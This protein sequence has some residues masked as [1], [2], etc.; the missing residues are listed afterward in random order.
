MRELRFCVRILAPDNPNNS[1]GTCPG[2]CQF[3]PTFGSLILPRFAEMFGAIDK[4]DS[5]C[6]LTLFRDSRTNE[7]DCDQ[8]LSGFIDPD[9]CGRDR[10]AA[11]HD[12]AEVKEPN[13]VRQGTERC[14]RRRKKLRDRWERNKRGACMT[15]LL[16]TERVRPLL[17]TTSIPQSSESSHT[18]GQIEHRILSEPSLWAEPPFG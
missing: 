12:Q 17:E 16:P 5:E 14:S 8:T 7:M 13:S 1:Q 10:R 9:P 11:R 6:R 15:S 4:P 18:S 2:I 3:L